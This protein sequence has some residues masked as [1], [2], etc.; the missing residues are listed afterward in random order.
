MDKIRQWFKNRRV[1]KQR[2]FYDRIRSLSEDKKKEFLA[3]A[4]MCAYYPLYM[5]MTA[6]EADNFVEGNIA[7]QTT[8]DSFHIEMRKLAK[9]EPKP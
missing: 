7:E 5:A 2:K 8:G 3:N 6:L 1:A 9:E 4:L